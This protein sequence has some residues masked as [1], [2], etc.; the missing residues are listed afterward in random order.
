[1]AE[2]RADMAAHSHDACC[3]ATSVWQTAVALYAILV[4]VAA[5][6]PRSWRP[7]SSWPNS[8]S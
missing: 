4:C 5:T 7:R 6:R 3:R 1:M 8:T 2:I